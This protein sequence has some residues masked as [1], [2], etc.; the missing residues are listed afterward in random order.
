MP[1]PVIAALLL[2]WWAV[3]STS[4]PELEQDG[5]NGPDNSG[6]D[7]KPQLPLAPRRGEH[8]RTTSSPPRIRSVTARA[9]Q[10]VDG[11]TDHEQTSR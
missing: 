11:A 7:P 2:V 8:D 5:G 3:R 1:V 10:R 6:P 4:E 9:K